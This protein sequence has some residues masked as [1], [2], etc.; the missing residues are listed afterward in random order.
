M[1]KISCGAHLGGESHVKTENSCFKKS[2]GLAPADS[3][4]NGSSG[5]VKAVGLL[6]AGCQPVR[7]A[8]GLKM[9]DLG[10]MSSAGR[11]PS[12]AA[13]GSWIINWN[14]MPPKVMTSFQLY[15]HSPQPQIRSTTGGG[16]AHV[17]GG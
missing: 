10:N 3:S 6:V 14:T 11:L 13:L 1:I 12:P 8:P 2:V 16:F 4:Y 9:L 17:D 15:K 7:G 5:K